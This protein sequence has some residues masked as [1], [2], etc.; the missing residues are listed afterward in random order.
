M[1]AEDLKQMLSLLAR[2]LLYFFCIYNLL[3]AAPLI[4]QSFFLLLNLQLDA[5]APNLQLKWALQLGANIYLA[6]VAIYCLFGL[7]SW[8]GPMLARMKWVTLMH[9]LVAAI[10]LAL[11]FGGRRGE[12]PDELGAQLL[13]AQS[14]FDWT[15]RNGSQVAATTLNWNLIQATRGC[16][17]WRNRNEWLAF[18]PKDWKTS[19][20][21]VYPA[22]C[23]L[24]PDQIA[25]MAGQSNQPLACN[26]SQ[27]F[28]EAC[29]TTGQL[30]KMSMVL[31]ALVHYAFW[32]LLVLELHAERSVLE[33]QLGASDHYELIVPIASQSRKIVGFN[34]IQ[35]V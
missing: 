1:A 28:S 5:R 13:A 15:A 17:G 8:Q 23:C 3:Q 20:A 16:C 7:F 27:A 33:R 4:W 26:A 6:L 25:T 19:G 35:M 10:I 9:A 2:A 21:L 34:S 29:S 11:M 31:L 24:E 18:K 30:D 32:A 12:A 14:K 22:S